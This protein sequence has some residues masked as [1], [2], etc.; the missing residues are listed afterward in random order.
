MGL[1]GKYRKGK[2]LDGLRHD[3]IHRESGH[4]Y[5]GA[6]EDWAKRASVELA[7]NDN[8]L[9]F[10]DDCISACK[11]YLKARDGANALAQARRALQGYELG[12]W[13]SG[14]D[15]DSDEYLQELTNVIAVMR[16]AGYPAEADAFL[17]DVNAALA[18][19]GRSPLMV[20]VVAG[21]YRFPNACPHCGAT[22]QGTGVDQKMFCPFC[23]G[24]VDALS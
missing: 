23:G 2:E 13:L 14:E 22:I 20:S 19:Y 10:A 8:E 24:E 9:I 15:D 1:F 6:A 18:K 12:D 5:V 11:D 17:S 4:D 3:A 21:G 16:E 7:A